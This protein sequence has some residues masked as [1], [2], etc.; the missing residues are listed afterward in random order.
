MRRR[1]QEIVP[2]LC[3]FSC[4]FFFNFVSFFFFFFVFIIFFLFIFIWGIRSPPS[5]KIVISGIPLHAHFEDIE[6]LLKP[7]GKVQHCDAVSSKDPNTQTVHITYETPE[8]AQRYFY[9][10]EPK[11]KINKQ[12]E[13]QNRKKKQNWILI[14]NHAN[15]NKCDRNHK[16]PSPI[17][18]WNTRN[19]RWACCYYFCSFTFLF[20]GHLLRWWKF[21]GRKPLTFLFEHKNLLLYMLLRFSNRIPDISSNPPSSI[22]FLHIP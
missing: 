2:P 4:C 20:F 7:Y 14:E 11:K 15:N 9:C 6:P 18:C 1:K 16:L 13:K 21:T 22:R 8:Q 10:F 5:S 12:T 19:F 17:I 3:W